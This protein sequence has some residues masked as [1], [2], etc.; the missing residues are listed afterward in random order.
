MRKTLVLFLYLAMI[1]VG[2]WATYEWL[3]LGGRGIA[4]RAGAF[5]ALFGVYLLWTD[6]LSPNREPL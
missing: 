4:F 6:F 2:S 3:V 5:L 1:G